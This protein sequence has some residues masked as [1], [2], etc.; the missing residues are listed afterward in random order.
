MNTG[1]DCPDRRARS[2]TQHIIEGVLTTR[3]CPR[4]VIVAD[5]PFPRIRAVV[6]LQPCKSILSDLDRCDSSRID[7]NVYFGVASEAAGLSCKFEGSFGHALLQAGELLSEP[8]GA[9]WV[10]RRQLTYFDAP[11]AYAG[12]SVGY[13]SAGWRITTYSTELKPT[14]QGFLAYPTAAPCDRG[15]IC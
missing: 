14:C 11:V 12:R 5:R 10:L 4:P 15:C 1:N 8:T 6:I 9:G 2:F 7:D 3:Y 13:A